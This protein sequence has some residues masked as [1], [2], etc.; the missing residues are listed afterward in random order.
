MHFVLPEEFSSESCGFRIKLFIVTIQCLDF[1]VLD[2]FRRVLCIVVKHSVNTTVIFLHDT[3]S[4][5][6]IRFV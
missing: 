5:F 1:V 4:R 3:S 2:T 6:S